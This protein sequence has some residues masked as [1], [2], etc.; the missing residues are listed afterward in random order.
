MLPARRMKAAAP[1]R[2]RNA[3]AAPA[4]E[5]AAHELFLF[6]TNDGDR[7]RRQIQPIIKNLA[8]KWENGTFNAIRA[9]DAFVAVAKSAARDYTK[10]YGS[11]RGY[12]I[13]N[14]P[15]TLHI[16][17]SAMLDAY[18]DEFVGEI[19][20]IRR[21]A[22]MAK[23]ETEGTKA[24]KNNRSGVQ[25]NGAGGKA[26]RNGTPSS[27]LMIFPNALQPN[28]Y[29]YLQWEPKHGSKGLVHAIFGVPYPALSF[30]EAKKVSEYV[31]LTTRTY[32]GGREDLVQLHDKA[33]ENALRAKEERLLGKTPRAVKMDNTY[34]SKRHEQA[35]QATRRLVG[36]KMNGL[37]L[38]KR[39]GA[40]PE[41]EILG[42]FA[43]YLDAGSVREGV[44]VAYTAKYGKT[45]PTDTKIGQGKIG[46]SP[47]GKGANV[48]FA[49]TSGNKRIGTGYFKPKH[50]SVWVTWA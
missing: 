31:G 11:G 23:I 43:E 6:A 37:A 36:V 25:R 34:W 3:T 48:Q 24:R 40:V 30:A 50:G 8:K 39:N 28:A 35:K 29:D 19:V 42:A 46:P 15:T 2:R 13:F 17:A 38:A 47:S 32:R 27:K 26:T 22:E 45:L 44:K 18:W 5:K 1:A 12:G 33:K 4:D 7:Y 21:H 41:A 20:S 16:A 14:N 9:V 49:I 10:Q